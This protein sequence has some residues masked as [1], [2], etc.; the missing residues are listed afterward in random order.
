MTKTRHMVVQFQLR[1]KH[2]ALIVYLALTAYPFVHLLFLYG[3]WLAAWCFLDHVPRP[4]LDDPKSINV[5][6]STY[7]SM[8]LVLLLCL[9]IGVVGS[10]LAVVLT[11]RSG[12]FL[13]P[14]EQFLI[15]FLIMAQWVLWITVIHYDPG[16]VL[17]WF[18][19]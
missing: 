5:L 17:N 15:M 14:L 16:H 12:K 18:M 13:L 9:P 6:I 7:H 2:L 19:D 8:T 10:M 3:T 1:R 4:S 11:F